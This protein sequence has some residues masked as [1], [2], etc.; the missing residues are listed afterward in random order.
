MIKKILLVFTVLFFG[1]SLI[2]YAQVPKI[3]IKVMTSV[4]SLVPDGLGRSRMFETNVEV[5]YMT[6]TSKQTEEKSDRNRSKRNDIRIKDY[7][8]TKL[9]NLYNEGGIRFQNIATND[10]LVTS[11]INEMLSEGWDL[12]FVETGVESK[13]ISSNVK[14][15]LLK[16]GLKALAGDDSKDDNKKDPNGIFLNRYYFK[17]EIK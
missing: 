13:M 5:D 10:A 6:Y 4:E 8:E 9:L 15:E 17:R 3:E 14:K 11:K 7:E 16:M 2:I 1:S 12:F